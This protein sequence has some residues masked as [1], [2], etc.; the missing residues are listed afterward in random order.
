VTA[1]RVRDVPWSLGAPEFYMLLAHERG[2]SPAVFANWLADAWARLLLR[3]EGPSR[4]RARGKYD[5]PG[6]ADGPSS[7]RAMVK[8]FTISNRSEL[9]VSEMV[10]RFTISH[11]VIARTPSGIRSALAVTASRPL[12]NRPTRP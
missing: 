8:R 9:L 12:E 1:D 6:G 10:K 5:G 4:L 2:W 3:G 11:G 7:C